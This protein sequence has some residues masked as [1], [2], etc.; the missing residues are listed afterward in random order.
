[1]SSAHASRR[2]F[3]ARSGKS[4]LVG[5]AGLTILADAR[6]ARAAPANDR[7]SL[8]IIGVRGRGHSLAGG[9]L[10]RDDCAVAHV[11]DVDASLGAARAADYAE[12]QGGR[13]VRCVQDC[14]GLLEQASVDAV[15]IAT[16]DH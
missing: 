10:Q 14:S 12:R 4:L 1:M 11:C 5:S 3:L 13:R 9:F 15:M 16:P 7:V 8:A 6:S 2:E